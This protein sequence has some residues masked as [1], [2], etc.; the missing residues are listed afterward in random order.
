[1]QVAFLNEVNR[2]YGRCAIPRNTKIGKQLLPECVQDNSGLRIN[3]KFL[4]T[5]LSISITEL[6]GVEFLS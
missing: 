6:H 4:R 5:G 1:M 3:I 2:S